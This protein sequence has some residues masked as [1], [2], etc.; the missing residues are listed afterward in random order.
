MNIRQ[1]KKLTIAALLLGLLLPASAQ[2]TL[3]LQD[4]RDMALQQNKQLAISKLQMDVAKDVRSSAKTKYL[5]RVDAVA[6]Y[7][8]TNRE[9]SLLNSSQKTALSNLGTNLT[10]A[11]GTDLSSTLTN[12]V[13]QGI[14]S[15]DMAQQLGALVGN[16]SGEIAQIGNNIGQ[17]IRDAFRT[18]TK[19]IWA[20]TVQVTQPVYMGGAIRAANDMACIGESMAANGVEL[21]RQNVL[22]SVDNAYWL[23]VS[24]KNKQ[25]LAQEYLD[26]V[27]HL[28]SD[29]HKMIN[30]GV[31]TR[32]D[33]LK[34]DVAV[35]TAEV[36]L[37]Q[38]ENGV[39]LSKMALCQLIGQPLDANICLADEAVSTKAGEGG[40]LLSYLSLSA[41]KADETAENGIMSA[42]SN[43]RPELSLLQNMIDMSQQSTK[44]IRSLYLPHV[45]ATGG[46]LVSN[47]NTFDGFQN[48]FGA[49]WNIGVLV[50]VPIWN[51]GESR[52]R[53]RA[54]RNATVMAQ[55]QLDDA[56]NLIDLQVQQSQFKLS[57]A[58]K[59][60]AAS[61][62]NMAAAEENLRCA[63]IGFKEGVMTITDVMN[64]QTAWQTAKSQQIDAQI[65]V[66]MAQTALAKAQG[67][68]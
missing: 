21:T 27:K 44:L 56:R 50:Q 66:R 7:T 18:N 59:R 63:N 41:E 29:V 43:L 38:V 57:E 46:V 51:W 64:A 26:L 16:S 6:G 11:L 4:C 37:T 24:L 5:P 60:A 14:L 10:G 34:V 61:T 58:Q 54:S 53:L 42:E 33:G 55:L 45:M 67:R 28:N 35:N 31:A 2:Q 39:S 1:M 3:S 68:L 25:Q 36:T 17:S 49:V 65:E 47:P 52:Y 13:Q 9:F 23:A 32:S 62:V 20:G 15:Q 12:L 40:R 19:N 48:K 30:E 8:H 22:F